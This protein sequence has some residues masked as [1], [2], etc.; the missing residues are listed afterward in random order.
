MVTAGLLLAGC[1]GGAETQPETA[2][3]SA[4]AALA[5]PAPPQ[6]ED[7]S[8]LSRTEAFERLHERLSTEY[9]FTEWKGVDWDALYAVH[10]PAVAAATNPSEYL[11]ALR[12]YLGEVPDGH[13]GIRPADDAG[14]AVV[15]DAVTAQSGGGY[16]MGLAELDDGRVIAAAVAPGSPAANAGMA[17]GA[18][19]L[20]W[21]GLPVAEAISGMDTTG[22]VGVSNTATSEA[23]RLEQV[24]M[25]ARGPVGAQAAVTFLNPGEAEPVTVEMQ[26]VADNLEWSKLLTF[27]PIPDLEAPPVSSQMI[28]S[29]I[30]YIRLTALADPDDLAAYPAAVAEQF[31]AAVTGLQAQG[32]T[33]LVVDLRSNIGGYDSLAATICGLFAEERSVYEIQS[34]FDTETGQFVEFTVDDRVGE[35]GEIVDALWVEPSPQAFPGPVVALV[36]PRTISSGEGVAMCIARSPQ[37]AVA[38][39]HGTNGSFGLAAPGIVT[40]PDGL[41]VSYPIGR[42]LDANRTIQLDSRDGVGGVAPN[43]E[44]ALTAEA[45]LAYAAGED[46]ELTAAVEYLRQVASQ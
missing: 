12:G 16:G 17:T 28:D 41:A 36:N 40:M 23:Q 31:T 8:S 34:Y 46:V 26:T 1:S 3:E 15:Q 11:V 42:S 6:P 35:E 25:L 21:N 5:Q 20:T 32:A 43:V 24:R 18:E 33:G 27:V 14:T 44:V 4:T 37:G 19:I 2:E 10:Q 9:A 22:L 13:V 30:G 38:G 7:L 45:A 39:F 29:D